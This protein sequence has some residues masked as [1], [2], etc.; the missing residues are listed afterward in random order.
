MENRIVSTVLFACLFAQALKVIYLIITERRIDLRRFFSTGGMPSSHASTVASLTTC[1]ARTEGINTPIFA[2][3]LAFTLVTLYDAAGI[4]RAAGKQAEVLNKII[5][6]W[7][8]DSADLLEGRL[9]E[10][11][12]H[13]PMEV[14]WGCTLG[15]VIGLLAKL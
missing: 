11:L 4:R 15:I 7:D 2:L 14:F 6:N 3:T 10:L 5:D 1:I 8:D 12:G 9:K 13:T